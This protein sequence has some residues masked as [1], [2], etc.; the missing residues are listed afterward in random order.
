MNLHFAGTSKL[1]HNTILAAIGCNFLTAFSIFKKTFKEKTTVDWDDRISFAVERAKRE[2]RIRGQATNSPP[3]SARGVPVSESG[4]KEEEFD[5]RNTPFQYHP[6]LYGPRGTLPEKVRATFSEVGPLPVR[7]VTARTDEV[8]LWMS[9]ANGSAPEIGSDQAAT[10]SEAQLG[11]FDA[12]QTPKMTFATN[13]D[14]SQTPA[15]FDSFMDRAMN[16]FETGNFD[17]D[18]SYPFEG[19]EDAVAGAEDVGNAVSGAQPTDSS[20]NQPAAVTDEMHDQ[21]LEGQT[22]V[23]EMVGQELLNLDTANNEPT[24]DTIG[25]NQAD[26]SEAADADGTKLDLGGSILGKRK[27]SPD[28]IDGILAGAAEHV[29]KSAKL[30]EVGETEAAIEDD[31]IATGL[32]FASGE[33]QMD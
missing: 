12:P 7:E 13:P 26:S 29:D 9:G 28:L 5:F 8:E 24:V 20:S 18:T 1:P 19:G 14:I 23:A 32:K 3:G 31:E 33:L 25:V 21:S 4:V 15:D 22:Q 11:D 17:F 6:P 2:K 30:T 16:D 10:Q 27:A